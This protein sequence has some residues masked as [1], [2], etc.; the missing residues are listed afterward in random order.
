MKSAIRALTIGGGTDAVSAAQKWP[1]VALR[2]AITGALL[3]LA[4]RHVHWSMIVAGL[5]RM[6]LAWFAA[7][8]A[9]LG[10]QIGVAA[11]RWR[12]IAQGCGVAMSAAAALRFLFIGQFFSQTLPATVGADSARIWYLGRSSGDWKSTAYSVVID[13]SIGGLALGILVVLI[14]PGAFAR[15]H[16]PAGRLSLVL[17]GCACLAAFASVIAVGALPLLDRW[18]VTRHAR[19]IALISGKLLRDTRSA[20]GIAVSSM[21]IHL[22]SVLAVWCIARALSAPLGPMDAVFLVPPV[23]LITMIPI[24]VAGWG[25][26]ENAMVVALGYAAIGNSQGLL[27]SILFGLG[28]F[29]LGLVGGAVWI[30][31]LRNG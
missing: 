8:V 9:A 15:I 3:W 5:A 1:G 6:H 29:V 17:V 12:W 19:A 22:L 31:S 23:M 26:R 2:M 4:F 21:A 10:L 7:A 14:L 25:V 28:S 24:S 30:A 20:R 13:R 16:D 18:R 27:I 11:Q